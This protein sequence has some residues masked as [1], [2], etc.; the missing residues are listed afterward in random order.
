MKNNLRHLCDS[1]TALTEEDIDIL[2]NLSTFLP[3]LSESYEGDVF[4]DCKTLDADTAIVVAE[5][6]KSNTSYQEEVVGKFAYR[7]NEPAALRT[8]DSG[9]KTSR[10]AGVS[11]ENV[12]I[13][14]STTAI[15]NK[16]KVIGVLIVETDITEEI[17]KMNKLDK[18]QIY[19]KDPSSS[20]VMPTV[21]DY[22]VDSLLIFNKDRFCDYLNTSAWAF[23]R[24]LGYRTDLLG[25]HFDNLAMEE[26]DFDSIVQ[27]K[28]IETKELYVGKF[29]LN[30]KYSFLN[31]GN[32][33]V[34]IIRDITELK[35]HQRE[36]INKSVAIQ[37]IHHRVKNN[38]QTIASLL[39]IQSR[40]L[41]NEVVKIAFQESISRILSIAVTHEILA[42][43]VGDTVEVQELL[44]KVV[45][46]TVYESQ[47]DNINKKLEVEVTGDKLYVNSS[48]GNTIALVVNELLSNAYQHA[49]SPDEKGKVDIII[50][51]TKL[52]NSVTVRDNGRGFDVEKMRTNSIGLNIVK[53]LSKET[54]NGDVTIK[55]DEKG[56][57]VV[58]KFLNEVK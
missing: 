18:N 47:S 11:Q 45:S 1:Y 43:N 20:Y 2:E 32:K 30:I 23:Y 36:L 4:I 10:L 15:K 22:V 35:D 54:L 29:C 19:E 24:K 41:E 5:H 40:R 7:K 26:I 51:S 25:M 12:P 50:T 42:K 3:L 14:Q 44:K 56:T 38:L 28:Y 6:L 31:R 49:F 34:M 39:R 13:L 52:A 53:G 48:K 46:N 58:I 9:V 21:S 27:K 55:S 37:E 17:V 33:I 57:E 16:G 8:L